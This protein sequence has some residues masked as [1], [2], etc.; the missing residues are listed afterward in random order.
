VQKRLNGQVSPKTEHRKRKK[1]KWRGRVNMVRTVR[2]LGE[3]NYLKEPLVS[4]KS[5]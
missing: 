3:K 5:T 1:G 2:F 4:N